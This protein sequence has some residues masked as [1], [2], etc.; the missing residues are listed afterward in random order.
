M[1]P[2]LSNYFLQCFSTVNLWSYFQISWYFNVIIILIIIYYSRH[3]YLISILETKSSRVDKVKFFGTQP[4]KIRTYHI[5]IIKKKKKTSYTNFTW[6]ILEELCPETAEICEESFTWHVHNFFSKTNH[7]YS[8]GVRNTSFSRKFCVRTKWM[9]QISHIII[10]Y[11]LVCPQSPK[12]NL[13]FAKSWVLFSN[14]FIMLKSLTTALM[15]P[16][17]TL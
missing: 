15:I 11:S 6:A 4:L 7:F 13:Y 17:Y 5:T 9:T 3:H 16:W 10:N 14:L 12:K 8:L 2:P 1:L